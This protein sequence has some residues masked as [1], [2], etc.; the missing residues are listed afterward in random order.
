MK[1]FPIKKYALYGGGVTICTLIV[2]VL[3][4]VDFREE[5]GT[6]SE[7]PPWLEESEEAELEE[8][9]EDGVLVVDVKGMVASPGVYELEVGSRLFEAIEK[10][11]GFTDSANREGVNL[12][13]RLEDEMVVYVPEEGEEEGAGPVLAVEMNET[14][15]EDTININE[16]TEADLLTLQGVGPSKAAAIIGYREENGPFATVEELMNVSGI[17]EKT[18]EALEPFIRVK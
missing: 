5:R 7:I 11:G 14:D 1:T 6:V 10:A 9:T 18:F 15:H 3:V 8:E 17:G 2:V 4:F 12:A 13:L 16:A